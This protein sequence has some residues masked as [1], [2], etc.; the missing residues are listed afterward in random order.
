MREIAQK[1]SS[2]QLVEKCSATI[3]VLRWVWVPTV[4]VHVQQIGPAVPNKFPLL[5]YSTNQDRSGFFGVVGV[6]VHRFFLGTSTPWY[7]ELEL[8]EQDVNCG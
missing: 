8:L 6:A 1:V 3:F 4:P 7:I 5:S 2:S